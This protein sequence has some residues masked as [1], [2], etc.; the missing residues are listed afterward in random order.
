MST[1][2]TSTRSS[3]EPPPVS[4]E[5]QENISNR[6]TLP[7]WKN[8]DVAA[9]REWVG[10]RV[11]YTYPDCGHTVKVTPESAAKKRGRCWDCQSR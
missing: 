9:C 5:W 11:S 4:H 8:G 2:A 6:T 3:P 10:Y 1:A 7:K